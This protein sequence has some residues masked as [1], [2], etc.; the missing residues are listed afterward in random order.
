MTFESA[1]DDLS[2]MRGLVE[3]G[4]DWQRP[5]GRVYFAAGLC[6]GAQM[7]MHGGQFVG[8]LPEAGWPALAIGLGPTGVFLVLLVWLNRLNGPLAGT[9]VARAVGSVFGAVG[10]ANLAI[11]AIVGSVAWREHSITIWLIYPCIVMALQGVAWMVAW[12]LRRRGWLGLVAAGW[13][14]TGLAMAASIEA[15][16]GY[17]LAAGLGMLGFLL[18]PGAIMMRQ[19][20]AA[21]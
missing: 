13:F 19:A 5:F 21:A 17:V 16:G 9:A 3:G 12:Q 10:V 6:Y 1:R 7:L 2:F 14:A 11:A 20:P 18:I 4:Q 8:V 15:I